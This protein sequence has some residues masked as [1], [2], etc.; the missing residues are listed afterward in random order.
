MALFIAAVFKYHAYKQSLI[1]H[2]FHATLDAMA[3]AGEIDPALLKRGI[4]PREV[5]RSSLVMVKR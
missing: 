5:K 3:A 4:I 1:V 2:D